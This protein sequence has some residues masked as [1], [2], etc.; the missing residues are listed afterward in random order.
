LKVLLV[1]GQLAKDRVKK[2][3]QLSEVESIVIDLPVS[4]A[5]FLSPISIANSLKQRDL[6]NFDAI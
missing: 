2:F 3:S 1:T 5:A 4:V 6:K